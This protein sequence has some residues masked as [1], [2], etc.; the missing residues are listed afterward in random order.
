MIIVETLEHEGWGY[1]TNSKN[2]QETKYI[3]QWEFDTEEDAITFVRSL[4]PRLRKITVR[5][6]PGIDS[7]R[8]GYR[9]AVRA[10]FNGGIIEMEV[11]IVSRKEDGTYTLVLGE[12]VPW[13]SVENAW[14]Y[15]S[16]IRVNGKPVPRPGKGIS[17][18]LTEPFLKGEPYVV[19]YD[20]S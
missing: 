14:G 7:I 8:S 15:L 20:E 16:N 2:N 12:H 18:Y 19:S 10:Q 1:D 5:A 11:E 13:W 3:G 9:G 17:E 4:I 6:T